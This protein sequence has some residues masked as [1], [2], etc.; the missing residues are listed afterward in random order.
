MPTAPTFGRRH[1]P[2]P[3]AIPPIPVA[4]LVSV[5]YSDVHITAVDDNQ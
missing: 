3:S 5:F 1:R 4:N 2:W